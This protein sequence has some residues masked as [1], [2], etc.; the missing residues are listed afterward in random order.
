[1]V[2]L[3]PLLLKGS[4]SLQIKNYVNESGRDF[5]AGPVAGMLWF[6]CRPCR[7]QPWSGN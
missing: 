5:L 1:M 4:M 6:Y 2:D 7:F 3:Y